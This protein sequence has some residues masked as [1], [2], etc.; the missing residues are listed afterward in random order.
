MTASKQ[1]QDGTEFGV[2]SLL[3]LEAVIITSMKYTNAE[4][5]VGDS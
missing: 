1:I 3:C 4:C 5:T 2:P